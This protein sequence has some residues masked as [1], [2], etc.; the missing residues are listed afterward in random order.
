MILTTEPGIT[1][2]STQYLI[3]KQ[4]FTEYEPSRLNNKVDTASLIKMVHETSM[5]FINS[6]EICSIFKQNCCT[7]C[8]QFNCI[9]NLPGST[10]QL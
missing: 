4:V 2:P 7:V 9:L 10:D 1:R 8:L 5:A 6:L 3:Y